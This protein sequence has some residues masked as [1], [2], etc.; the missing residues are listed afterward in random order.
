MRLSA[1]TK[2]RLAGF[3]LAFALT[4]AALASFSMAWGQTG[5]Q[6]QAAS[7]ARGAKLV[8]EKCARCHATG[9]TDKSPNA[10]AP[11]FRDVGKRYPPEHLAEAL[12][13]GITTRAVEMPEFKFAPKDV[14]AIIDYLDAMAN[15]PSP[16]K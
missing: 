8:Q 4:L 13:E 6:D 3:G 11:P 15:E 16:K 5:S 10:K 7:V 2:E 9:S 1:W 14:D 12:A